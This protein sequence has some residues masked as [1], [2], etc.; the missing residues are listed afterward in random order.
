MDR[1]EVA[2]KLREQNGD[3]M[4]VV[5]V[6]GYQEDARRLDEAGFNAHMIKPPDP[7]RLASL[8]AAQDRPEGGGP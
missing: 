1:Y 8:L 2:Q 4:L 7:D 3:Q 5:A 6:T